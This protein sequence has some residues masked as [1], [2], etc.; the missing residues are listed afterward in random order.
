MKS[1]QCSPQ[2]LEFPLVGD[3]FAFRQFQRFQHLFHFLQGF[4]QVMDD[5]LNILDSL[6]NG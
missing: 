3:L 1:S 4:F 5:V 2:L 6:V